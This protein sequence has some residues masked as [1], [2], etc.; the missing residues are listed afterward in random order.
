VLIVSGSSEI[1]AI[2]VQAVVASQL[3]LALGQRI[4]ERF[5]ERAGQLA[6]VALVLL[7]SYLI[8]ERLLAQ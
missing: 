2:A 4:S 7:G 3:G 8:L 6:A 1:I 5:R